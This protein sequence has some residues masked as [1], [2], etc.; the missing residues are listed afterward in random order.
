VLTPP[1]QPPQRDPAD[2]GQITVLVLGYTAIAAL[3]V[4][5]G[6]DTSSAFL[7]RRALAAAADDAAV[8]AAG[9]VSSGD[10][11][12][13]GVVCGRSLPLDPQRAAGAASA[14]VAADTDLAG[15]FGTAT[16]PL[17]TVTG[18]TATVTL[19]GTVRLPLASI[20]GVVDPAVRDGVRISVT[21]SAESP[22]AGC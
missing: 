13:G 10:V 18:G 11:Y 7:A 6:I 12:A 2:S 15:A 21:A 4:V 17:T 1:R 19:T 5:V 14:S 22:V 8:A 16:R 20:T 9:S 3:L